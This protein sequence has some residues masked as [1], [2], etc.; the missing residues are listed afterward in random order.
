MCDV[1]FFKFGP[2]IILWNIIL[3][4]RLQLAWDKPGAWWNLSGWEARQ[5]DLPEQMNH[6]LADVSGSQAS[7]G[8]W[9]VAEEKYFWGKHSHCVHGIYFIFK[10]EHVDV[11]AE[12]CPSIIISLCFFLS[13]WP[14]QLHFCT[15]R[16]KKRFHNKYF[17]FLIKLFFLNTGM[18]LRK[19]KWG[20]V[21]DC[22]G[23]STLSVQLYTHMLAV[24]RDPQKAEWE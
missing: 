16:K 18:Q 15:K 8:S 7:W 19:A 23:G 13:F 9:G 11:E 17:C 2:L 1:W 14:L 5:M 6:E 24:A 12:K 22:L 3:D 20:L 21:L 4:Q 10:V